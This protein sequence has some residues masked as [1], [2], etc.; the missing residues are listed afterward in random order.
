MHDYFCIDERHP[1][2][3]T[4]G[5][6]AH[7]TYTEFSVYNPTTGGL[8]GRVVQM[9]AERVDGL[10]HARDRQPI[11]CPLIVGGEVLII[12]GKLPANVL[13]AMLIALR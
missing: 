3:D 4:P 13:A 10:M 1:G 9:R 11:P 5:L 6:C 2:P 8:R 12:G 7:I